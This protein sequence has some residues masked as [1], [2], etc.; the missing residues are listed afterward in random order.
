MN[1]QIYVFH[2][3]EVLDSRCWSIL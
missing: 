2:N 1:L 3:N